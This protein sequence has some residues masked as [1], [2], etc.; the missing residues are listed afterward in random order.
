MRVGAGVQGVQDYRVLHITL[1]SHR[2]A[3]H[4]SITA[5]VYLSTDIMFVVMEIHVHVCSLACSLLE[6]KGEG[7]RGG[8]G[9]LEDSHDS[10]RWL[11]S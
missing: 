6:V 4:I 5:S 3:R 1:L 11:L 8:E 2:K 7:G 10:P 9:S